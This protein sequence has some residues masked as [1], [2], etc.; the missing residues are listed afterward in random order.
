ML[1]VAAVKSTNVVVEIPADL[2]SCRRAPNRRVTAC[3]QR[4]RRRRRCS[5]PAGSSSSGGSGPHC[6][7]VELGQ[8]G[9][10]RDDHRLRRGVAD[11]GVHRRSGS[12]SRPPTRASRST[13]NFGASSA[14]ADADH[15]GAP[16]DVFASASTTNMEQVVDRRRRDQPDELRRRTS[17]RSPPRR[18]TRPRSTSVDD[19]A[20]SGVKV[21]LCQPQVPVRRRPRRRCS[22]TP[23]I[24]VKPVTEE[25]D[26]KSVLTKVTLG[27]VDAG[28]VY[29]TDV[30][31]AGDKVKGVEIPDERQRLDDL[32]DRRPDQGAPNAA[33]AQRSSAYVLS[34]DGPE[35]ARRPPASSRPDCAALRPR[36]QSAARRLSPAERAQ[37]A[38]RGGSPAARPCRCSSRRSSRSRSCCCR[39]SGCWSGRRGAARPDPADRRR[40]SGA[41]AV[42]VD[43]D[44]SRPRSS[45]RARRAAGLGAGP[46]PA[47]RAARPARA[48]D[49]AAGAAAGGRRRRAAARVRPRRASSGSYL[50]AVVRHHPPVH[51][52]GRRHR[53]DVRRDAVPGHH[54]RGRAAGPP[55][56]GT[57]RPRPPSARAG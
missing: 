12:S 24:T 13:F 48:G 41:V 7:L 17:W 51:T 33:A 45:L 14:L 18:P 27:E 10:H 38:E 30:Q 37:R 11:G 6:G 5:P 20:K 19:L 46:D 36:D 22:P 35:R 53:R 4:L 29:V 16:A 44:A 2:R 31:A 56:R 39:W 43:G 47:A 3:L 8:P 54:R 26:V 32:P 9:R 34:P 25:P 42:A 40:R 52:A 28:V 50:D 57:R 49:P 1:A 21:A 23:S 15:Q 55:T